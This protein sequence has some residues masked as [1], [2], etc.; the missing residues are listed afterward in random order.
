MPKPKKWSFV[1][2]ASVIVLLM[3]VS[4]YWLFRDDYQILFSGLS[5]QD[6]SAVVTELEKAK[7]P[8]RLD[9]DGSTIMVNKESVYRT[10]LKL[11]GKGVD[12]HGTVG[13]EI[14][15]NADYGVTEFAQK[16]NYLRALQ[17]ELAR[18]IMG[19]DE[20]KTARVHLV[21]PESGLFHRE[22]NKPKASINLTMKDGA[23]LS[24]EQIKGIQ[25]LV[26]AAVQGIDP[27]LVT[28][29]DHRGVAVSKIS[30][31]DLSKPDVMDRLQIKKEMEAYLTRKIVD[32]LDRAVGVG[33][34]VVSVDATINYDQSKITREEVTPLPN[35][36]GQSV[37]AVVRKREQYQNADHGVSADSAIHD[38][39]LQP[40]DAVVLNTSTEIEYQNGKKVE[41]I[42][43]APGNLKQITVGVLVPDADPVKL[44]KIKEIVSM[45]IGANAQRGDSVVVYDLLSTDSKSDAN[46]KAA[47]PPRTA[48]AQNSW[49]TN[50]TENQTK[51]AGVFLIVA[52]M[53]LALA[54]AQRRRRKVEQ[55]TK[56]LLEINQWIGKGAI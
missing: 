28:V 30:S 18:T 47:E 51:L 8:Y 34:A 41:Q 14:F 29:I 53:V 15:N 4:V 32:V 42:I 44:A 23:E 16:V 49:L 35:T 46:I 45:A 17:G 1:A 26:A 5:P 31:E 43:A 54:F 48:G 3:L 50:I 19:L 55:R 11:M 22:Q 36:F 6:A 24:V 40:T 13:F 37:G 2:L 52:L 27:E 38:R 9:H 20:V 39:K 10:R 21:L 33:K 7:T 12:L 25:R 56:L